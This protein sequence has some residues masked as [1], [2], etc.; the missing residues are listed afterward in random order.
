MSIFNSLGSNY[1]FT[2][3]VRSLLKKDAGS[4]QKLINLLEKKYGGQTV[5]TYKGR[6]AIV[7][8][9]TACGFPQNSG[10]A[11]NSFTCIAVIEAIE[12][13]NL[14]PI[15]LDCEKDTLNFS[16]LALQNALKEQDIK[17]VIIQNTLGYPCDIEGIL[18]ICKENKLILIEDLAHC[19]GLIY[20]NGEEAGRVGDFTVLSFG[21]DKVID[22][23][24]G[25]AVIARN[26]KYKLHVS[27]H[28][29]EKT[30]MRDKAYPLLTFLIRN[31]YAIKIGKMLHFGA[32]KLRL[33]SNPM[34]PG[35]QNNM[36][37]WHAMLAL[38]EFLNLEKNL[39]HKR[40][41]ANM[42]LHELDKKFISSY[43]LKTAASASHLR[44][45]IYVKNRDEAV[46][47]LK[48][49]NMY[50]SSIWYKNSVTS[51]YPHAHT[52]HTNQRMQEIVNLP[53]H[54]NITPEIAK[55]IISII[56]KIK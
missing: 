2:Y 18:K 39:Q 14:I 21:Q 40:S 43:L 13:A 16:S 35:V 19:V 53:T 56:N 24:S 37:D 20:E 15:F 4:R 36:T 30:N 51:A 3:V 49:N 11:V 10:V 25:G 45:P 47:K 41:I 12:Q 1:N 55:E 8:A 23:V 27:K 54:I 17:A 29:H 50:L 5:L 9:L 46:E 38:N 48:D 33:L 22:S 7:K 31:T 44:F 34:K 52:P 26:E 42:Y 32:N 28:I 6:Q